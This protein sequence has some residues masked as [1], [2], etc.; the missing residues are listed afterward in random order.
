M[1]VAAE[2]EYDPANN[3]ECS[4]H[5]IA[6]IFVPHSYLTGRDASLSLRLSS[7]GVQEQPLP[8]KDLPLDILNFFYQ[9]LLLSGLHELHIG[10][11]SLLEAEVDGGV[12][13]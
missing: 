12:M 2:Y 1:T 10:S 4:Q 6:L 8:A 11:P 13:T 7:K 3:S 9:K 5:P